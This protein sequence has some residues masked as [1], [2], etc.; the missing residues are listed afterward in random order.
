M[1]VGAFAVAAPSSPGQIGVFHMGVIAA[2]T[3]LGM[4][5]E[6]A[7]SLAIL[8]HAINFGIMVL[9]GIMGLF[10][11][12][13]PLTRLSHS[14]GIKLGS[15]ALELPSRLSEKENGTLISLINTDK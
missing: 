7:A 9:F 3:L 10:I 15:P 13:V 12:N 4:S 11:A 5:A 14:L 8:Y 6:T 2:M 1:I